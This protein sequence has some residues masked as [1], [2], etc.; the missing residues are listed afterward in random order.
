MGREAAL[1]C[2][3]EEC[4]TLP[5]ALSQSSILVDQLILAVIIHGR[6]WEPL[7]GGRLGEAAQ[8]LQQQG[9]HQAGTE[10]P[11]H[12]RRPEREKGH[13]SPTHCSLSSFPSLSSEVATATGP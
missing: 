6:T 11:T 7:Q 4:E 13:Y 8:Q 12:L 5:F 9:R 3:A 10:H 2:F 1:T